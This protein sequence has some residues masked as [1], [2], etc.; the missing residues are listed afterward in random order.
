[1]IIIN[2]LISLLLVFLLCLPI[3]FAEPNISFSLYGY[4]D[5]SSNVNWIDNSFFKRWGEKFNIEFDLKAYRDKTEYYNYINSLSDSSDLPDVFF[6]ANLNTTQ[7]IDLYNKNVI[8]DLTQY[9]DEYMPELKKTL[10]NNPDIRD[11]ITVDG[12]IL[13]LPYINMVPSQNYIWINK[14][15]LDN[16]K[17]DLPKTPEEFKNVLT[18]FKDNDPNGNNQSDEIPII[19]NG[20]WDAKFLSHSFGIISDDFNLSFSNDKLDFA[21]TSQNYYDFIDYLKQLYNDGLIDKNCF[22]PKLNLNN[23]KLKKSIYGVIISPNPYSYGNSDFSKEYIIMPPL[24]NNGEQVYR[25]FNKKAIPGT[26]AISSKCRDVPTILKAVDY[27]Y[28]ADGSKLISIGEENEEYR[29]FDDGTWDWINSDSKS[30]Q[31][32]LSNITLSAGGFAPYIET[33]E[34]LKEYSNKDASSFLMEME[35][36]RKYLKSPMPPLQLSMQDIDYLKPLQYK[37]GKYTDEMITRFVLGEIILDD[38]TWND[39]KS[40][41]IDLGLEEFIEFWQNKVM[42]K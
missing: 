1:M 13:T 3:A 33:N 21:P 40:T 23:E 14:V 9:I 38:V 18:A 26:L 29:V 35:D 17:L 10:A 6:K 31:N 2:K 22:Y 39:F 15:W 12:K 11:I 34:F 42:E 27:L 36:F 8:V 7:A 25:E 41:L 30:I 28:S 24:S 19:F 16:L 5:E 20:I 37:I 4:E 32:V